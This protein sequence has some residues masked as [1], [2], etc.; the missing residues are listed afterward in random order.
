MTEKPIILVVDDELVNRSMAAAMLTEAGWRVDTA[1]DGPSALIAVTQ[2]SYAVILMDIQMAGM[3]GFDTAMSIR[4]GNGV[5]AVVPIL[6]FTALTRSEA[7]TRL[8]SSGMDGYIAKPFSASD[9]VAAVE[10]WRP[11][12]APY[13]A[14]RLAALFGEAEIDAMLGR[15][16]QQ[17]AEA[18]TAPDSRAERRTRAHRVAGIAGTLGFPEVSATWLAV[19]E[20]EDSQWETA[21]VAA[22]RALTALSLAVESCEETDPRSRSARLALRE[23]PGAHSSG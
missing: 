21:R 22:R 8:Q 11:L 2:R 4:A 7:E 3:N 1:E 14:A 6:A 9:L 19:A 20:G 10:P 5:A 16:R 17:L 13:S 12:T 18:L 15:F 23:R